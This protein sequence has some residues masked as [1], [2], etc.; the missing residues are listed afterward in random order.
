M[1]AISVPAAGQLAGTTTQEVADVAPQT[2]VRVLV[3]PSCENCG[4]EARDE[5]VANETLLCT[6]CKRRYRLFA[7]V[8]TIVSWALVFGMVLYVV[9]HVVAITTH[10]SPLSRVRPGLTDTELWAF[11]LGVIVGLIVHEGAHALWARGFGLDVSVVQL[12]TGPV[13]FRCK[14]FGTSPCQSISCRWA[15]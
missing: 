9:P 1:D 11:Y 13:L 5:P 15:A 3:E 8:H 2:A 4:C 12:G 14:V 6:G 10:Q 7:A